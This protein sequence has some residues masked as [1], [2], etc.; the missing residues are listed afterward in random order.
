VLCLDL[1]SRLLL[2]SWSIEL[3]N[4]VWGWGYHWGVML[5]LECKW[6]LIVAGRLERSRLEGVLHADRS[7]GPVLGCSV[8][9]E[10]S[11][12]VGAPM[13][14]SPRANRRPLAQANTETRSRGLN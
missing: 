9:L 8:A 4:G 7:L 12:V 2:R 3:E 5:R 13:S 6:P 11:G 10:S 14:G 1:G